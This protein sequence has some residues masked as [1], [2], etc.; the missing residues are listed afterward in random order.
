MTYQLAQLNIAKAKALIGSV[1]L[2]PFVAEL[3]RINTLAEQSPGFI[4]RLEDESGNATSIQIY[5]DPNMIIN[6]SV[7]ENTEALFD[8]VY[9]SAHTGVMARR[10]EW[11]EPMQEAYHVLWWIDAGSIPNLEQAKQRLEYLRAHGPS[12]YAFTFKKPFPA[13][14]DEFKD[15]E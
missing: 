11:F 7:W 8:Y 13:P 10:R 6:M 3:D 12:A 1:L 9:T 4:W 5:D 14:V 2:A 15:S